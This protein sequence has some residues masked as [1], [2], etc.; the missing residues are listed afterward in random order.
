MKMKFMERKHLYCSRHTGRLRVMEACCEFSRV[1]NAKQNNIK[2]VQRFLG[3]LLRWL[4]QHSVLHSVSRLHYL[5]QDWCMSQIQERTS[6]DR[7]HVHQLTYSVV[8]L[9]GNRLTSNRFWNRHPVRILM[10]ISTQALRHNILG[11]KNTVINNN[12]MKMCYFWEVFNKPKIWSEVN[13]QWIITIRRR[14]VRIWV[15]RIWL[16]LLVG[17]SRSHLLGTC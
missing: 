5:P 8:M 1:A 17:C 16:R 13:K 9:N 15:F 14:R 4:T 2:S 6:G 12:S 7:D 3:W 10:Q 11:D